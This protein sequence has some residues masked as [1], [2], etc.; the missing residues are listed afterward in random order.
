VLGFDVEY[1][2]LDLDIRPTLPAMLQLAAPG[3]SG[4]VGLIWLDKFPNHGK[5]ALLKDTTKDHYEPLT[6]LLADPTIYKV[7]V[8]SGADAVNLASWWGINDREYM[9]HFIA[10]IQELDHLP[11]LD[12]FLEKTDDDVGYQMP[13]IK[14][15]N[16]LSDLCAVVLDRKLTKK[17]YKNKNKD[18]KK[19]HWRA[20]E[21]L[22]RMK[23]YAAEDAASAV[24]IWMKLKKISASVVT[25]G[26]EKAP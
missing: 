13:T 5:D 18:A 20:P 16:K 1:A 6:T 3:P 8:N 9:E 10:G 15:V 22:D 21:L 25:P 12:S 7:G 24:D 4:P 11:E 26:T 2:T 14:S 19:S 23:S 17:K